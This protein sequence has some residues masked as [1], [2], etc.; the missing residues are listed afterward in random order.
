MLISILRHSPVRFKFQ[1][2]MKLLL[3]TSKDSSLGKSI[4]SIKCCRNTLK[5]NITMLACVFTELE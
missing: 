2:E 3:P 5:N 4:L 1:V